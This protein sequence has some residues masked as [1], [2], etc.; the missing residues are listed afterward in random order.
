MK[1]NHTLLRNISV[2]FFL[3]LI[4][5]SCGQREDSARETRAAET[6]SKPQIDMSGPKFEVNVLSVNTETNRTELELINRNDKPVRNI[7]GLLHLLDA[8]GNPLTFANGNPKTSNFQQ[9]QNPFLVDS[10]DKAV[11]RLG[12]SLDPN[13]VTVRVEI[14]SVEG[15]NGEALA[16][17]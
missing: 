10:K 13:T 3:T 12:N 15:P 17:E 14:T 6:N 1:T 7:R 8:N 11:I 4:S 5:L 9:I 16:L 2:C